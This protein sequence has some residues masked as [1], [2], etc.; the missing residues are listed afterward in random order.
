MKKVIL[1]SFLSILIITSATAGVATFDSYPKGIYEFSSTQTGETLTWDLKD[2]DEYQINS[3][4]IRPAQGSCSTGTNSLRQNVLVA[5]DPSGTSVDIVVDL[6]LSELFA[7][8][9]PGL[10]E[11][12]VWNNQAIAYEGDDGAYV[13]Y[14]VA[15]KITGTNNTRTHT[16]FLVKIYGENIAGFDDLVEATQD[17]PIILFAF[18]A[19]VII[20]VY[21][22][23]TQLNTK[24]K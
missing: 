3:Y 24:K 8:L 20:L 6:T 7:T 5:E 2:I 17:N 16:A 9:L 13:C 23:R 11:D 1:F 14:A 12:E 21:L 19:V 22:V 4:G 10:E 15:M 18:I